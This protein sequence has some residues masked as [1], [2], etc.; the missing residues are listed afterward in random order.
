MEHHLDPPHGAANQVEVVQISRD[1]VNQIPNAGE[2][3]QGACAQV[4]NDANELSLLHQGFNQVRANESRPA[5][6]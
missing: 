3:S 6:H 2:I 5:R 1:Q 4:V